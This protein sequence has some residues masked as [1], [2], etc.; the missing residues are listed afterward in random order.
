DALRHH[1]GAVDR[2]GTLTIRI[3]RVVPGERGARGNGSAEGA[4][5]RVDQQLRGVEA[6]TLAGRP[7]SLHAVAVELSR[8]HVGEVGVPHEAVPLGE[9][10]A[11]RF[12]R[13]VCPVEEAELHAGGVL[14][15]ERE[16]HALA[17]PRGAERVRAAWPD[18]HL[19]LFTG[20]AAGRESY[21]G[22][23]AAAQRVGVQDASGA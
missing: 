3:A 5:I 9:R 21:A 11:R 22:E 2:T 15:E 16:V 17:V 8:S 12:V 20:A 10:D 19:Q 14:R 18:A 6:V 13:V 23:G 4:G 1:A 7:G